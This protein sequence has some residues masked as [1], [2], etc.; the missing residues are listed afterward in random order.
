MSRGDKRRAIRMSHRGHATVAIISRHRYRVVCA[1]SIFLDLAP[2]GEGMY[3]LEHTPSPLCLSLSL[4]RGFFLLLSFAFFASHACTYTHIYTLYRRNEF[5]VIFSLSSRED[6]F[7]APT[8]TVV[9]RTLSRANKIRAR[10]VVVLTPNCRRPK[11]GA[12]ERE[13]THFAQM[14]RDLFDLSP[15]F[16]S[17]CFSC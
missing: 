13:K 15:L 2:R 14:R 3:Y 16:L 17:L 11:V 8:G 9:A 1:L 7:P 12:R 6:I 4:S 10:S 5:T